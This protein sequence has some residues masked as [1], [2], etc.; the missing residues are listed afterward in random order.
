MVKTFINR[1]QHIFHIIRKGVYLIVVVGLVAY[2]YL[3]GAKPWHYLFENWQTFLA[4]VVI[5]G[6]AI[7]VQAASF[8]E[9]QPIGSSRLSWVEL[10]RI[11]SFS[12]IV[13]VIAP[14][15]AGLATRTT[16]LV[17]AGMTL[18][19]CMVASARQIWVGLE[20]ALLLGGIAG[21]F[22]EYPGIEFF[23]ALFVVVG[24]AMILLRLYEAGFQA[25]S[26]ARGLRWMESF[27]LPVVGRAHPWFIAQLGV[28][29]TIYYVTFNGL[30]A[31]M[32]WHE[33]MM[34][35]TVTIL[36]SLIIVVPNGLGIMD[37]LW[38]IVAKESGLGL[39]ESVALAII[40]RL[41]YLV[42]AVMIWATLFFARNVM[43]RNDER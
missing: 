1:Y 26:C 39:E 11:W 9:V 40:V 13:S 20:Y 30:G 5:S 18:P 12:G 15:F 29:A 25:R 3:L 21:F 19:V 10:T 4:V 2:L 7:F 16:L 35:S 36:A 17:E 23:A 6:V 34:L 41:A 28:M 8:R 31:T 37:V 38:V 43:S 27:R 32:G 14:V 22:V 33:A 42:S 24:M